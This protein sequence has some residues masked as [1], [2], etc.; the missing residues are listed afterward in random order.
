MHEQAFEDDLDVFGVSED[1]FDLRSATAGAHN[2][3]IATSRSAE[4]FA[5]EDKRRARNEVRLADDE[6]AALRDLDDD[7]IRQRRL[8]LEE[9]ADRE[10]RTGRAECEAD[11]E[12]D[13]RVQRESERVHVAA[14]LERP[15]Q[16]RR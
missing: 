4:A 14:G 8:D 10:P 15:V 2:D 16:K 13:Q 6:L 12:E 11:A 3:E 1:T 7:A 5:I 9:A